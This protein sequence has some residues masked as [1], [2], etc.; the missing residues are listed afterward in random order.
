[1]IEH[2]A[3]TQE[4]LEHHIKPFW[5]QF[6]DTILYWSLLLIAI[7]A[8]LIL[9]V[10]LVP[11]LLVL[12]GWYLYFTLAVIAFCFGWV[13]SFILH[14]I[15]QLKTQQHIIAGLFI[16]AIALIT[17]GMFTILSNKLIVLMK[18]ATPE[19]SPVLVAFV[20]VIAYVVPQGMMHAMK[21][22]TES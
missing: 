5:T 14:S 1:M 7:L 4:I 6:L 15:E 22:N 9:S 8:N 3:K 13:F 11:L 2:A 19:H 12:K 10:V 17:I 16:P 21:K 20:Y 18:L